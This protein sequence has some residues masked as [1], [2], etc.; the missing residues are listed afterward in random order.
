MQVR[1]M[2][3]LVQP[4]PTATLTDKPANPIWLN[5]FNAVY[6]LLGLAP[7]ISQGIVAPT[8]TPAKVGDVY[9]DTILRQVYVAV[10]TT[11]SADWELLN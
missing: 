1:D 9:V 6:R 8:S 7:T 11:S 3:N 5:W 2:R 10:G 4:P